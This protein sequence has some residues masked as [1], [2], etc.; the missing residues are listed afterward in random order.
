MKQL[1]AINSRSKGDTIVEVLIAL[2]VMASILVG[3]FAVAS[4][5]ARNIRTSQEHSEALQLLQG[6]IE[7]LRAYAMAGNKTPESVVGPVDFCLKN[8]AISTTLDPDCTS[9]LYKYS[10][11]TDSTDVLNVVQFTGTVTWDALGGGQNQE[12]LTYRIPFE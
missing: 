5:S 1:F 10:F 4:A 6:Q 9:T 12:H 7:Q 3:A 2:A 11:K 8:G